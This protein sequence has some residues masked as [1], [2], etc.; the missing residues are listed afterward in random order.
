MID[1]KCIAVDGRLCAKL[2][3]ISICKIIICII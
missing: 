2:L 3:L 1:S